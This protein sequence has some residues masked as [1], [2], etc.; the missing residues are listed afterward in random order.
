[1]VW[2]KWR[3]GSVAVETA[4]MLP[5]VALVLGGFTELYFYARAVAIVERA[6]FT[7]ADS[8]AKQV[9]LSECAE[10]TSSTFLGTH[11]LTAKVTAQPLQMATSGQVIVSGVIDKDGKPVVAWQR[12]STFTQNKSSSLG[13]TGAQPAL[14]GGIVVAA[15][16]GTQADTLISAEVFYKFE[17]FAGT[18]T[19]LPDLPGSVTITRQA[20]ARARV[21]SLANLATG[22]CGA[23]LPA[24]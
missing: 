3:R 15:I 21:G 4:L 5:L 18:R 1:M 16:A 20:F 13:K 19:F 11:M 17:P 23:A 9:T 10:E 8:V 6:A 7:V 14:P 24:P 12:R 22:G 2:T